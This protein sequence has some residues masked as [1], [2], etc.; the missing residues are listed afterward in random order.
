MPQPHQ[1]K[2]FGVEITDDV[3]VVSPK[4]DSQ[5]FRRNDIHHETNSVIAHLQGDRS[6]CVLIDFGDVSI[7]SS[8][9]INATVRIIRQ[10]R[11]GRVAF[12]GSSPDMRYMFESMNL[13]NLWPYFD[14]RAEALSS[15]VS[16]EDA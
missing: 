12:C 10:Q 14:S 15:F 5:G 9:M 6:R 3:L 7:A 16:S 2:V 1:S 13:T 11:K 4:G 8:V